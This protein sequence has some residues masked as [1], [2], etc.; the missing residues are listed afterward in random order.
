MKWGGKDE[1]DQDDYKVTQISIWLTLATFVCLWI[2]VEFPF[3]VVGFVFF[4]LA[5]IIGVAASC[6]FLISGLLKSL[7]G[8]KKC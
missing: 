8:G 1:Q 6:G 2:F 4:A 7:K 5:I 3:T